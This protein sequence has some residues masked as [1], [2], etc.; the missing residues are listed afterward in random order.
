MADS[1]LESP[2]STVVDPEAVEEALQTQ[3]QEEVRK[4][5]EARRMVHQEEDSEAVEAADAVHLEE[6]SATAA[7]VADGSVGLGRA[8]RDER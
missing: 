7:M 2:P 6:G 1:H 5:E 8:A 4:E 3:P